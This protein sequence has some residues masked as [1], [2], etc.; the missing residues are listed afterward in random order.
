MVEAET[1]K[2]DVEHC[3]ATALAN[4]VLP[5]PGGPNMRTPFHGLRMPWKYSGMTSGK[6]TASSRSDLA[7][8]RPA[9]DS[10][11]T[12]GHRSTQSRSSIWIKSASGPLPLL[13]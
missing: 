13:P 2:K 6:T 4:M 10:H 3:V 1:L 11:V 5:V 9:M 7:C 12:E 8:S